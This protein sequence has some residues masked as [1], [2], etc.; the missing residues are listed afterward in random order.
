MHIS[1]KPETD[2][3]KFNKHKIIDTEGAVKKGLSDYDYN[4]EQLDS[5]GETIND[6]QSLQSPQESLTF[7]CKPFDLM[8]K[9]PIQAIASCSGSIGFHCR[10]LITALFN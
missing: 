9:I 1:E 6:E 5:R 8:F 2:L 3:L 10:Q 7:L 4:F